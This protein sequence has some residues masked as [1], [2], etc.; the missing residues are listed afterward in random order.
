MLES[1]AGENTAEVELDVE[2]GAL[3]FAIR[4]STLGSSMWE[5][6]L[7]RPQDLE[8]TSDCSSPRTAE[9][10]SFRIAISSIS[11]SV[12]CNTGTS[13]PPQSFSLEIL[14][15]NEAPDSVE[16]RGKFEVAEYTPAGALL[17]SV[18][19]RDPDS[20]NI[21]CTA[22]RP[23]TYRLVGTIPK[24][25]G[26]VAADGFADVV[27]IA[28]VPT[29]FYPPGLTVGIESTD[30]GGLTVT[31]P[32]VINVTNVNQPPSFD[33]SISLA[34]H[35][36]LSPGM[37]LPRIE[38]SDPDPA[39]APDLFGV[40]SYSWNPSTP[41]DTRDIFNLDEDTG[42]IFVDG[43]VYGIAWFDLSLVATDGG[44]ASAT[45]NFT[46]KVIGTTTTVTPTS[47][48]TRTDTTSVTTSATTTYTD[49]RSTT[50]TTTDSSSQTTSET[51]STTLT[52]SQ[53]RQRRGYP[54]T[55]RHL[56]G[57]ILYDKMKPHTHV[58]LCLPMSPFL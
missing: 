38:A 37:L 42:D 28:P 18:R 30:E 47:T 4:R 2:K 58:N 29:Y 57:K 1:S 27:T 15:V 48:P 44:G 32:F 43:Q 8:T 23:H 12:A 45:V 13:P 17:F 46:I 5:L 33:S 11:S 20:D 3:D 9:F 34:S 50:Y 49:T 53:V 39:D 22:A 36:A 10:R 31:V 54:H 19:T 16:G 24:W 51:T 35:E 52:S 55:A 25:I 41:V 56:P 7:A 40:L 6:V 14:N 21:A 26:L